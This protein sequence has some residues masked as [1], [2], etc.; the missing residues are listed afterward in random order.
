MF[1]GIVRLG[2]WVCGFE[3]SLGIGGGGEVVYK[4]Y[5]IILACLHTSLYYRKSGN[6]FISLVVS[7]F[8]LRDEIS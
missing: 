1:V 2:E 5:K 3:N 4:M 6:N 8:M 7:M